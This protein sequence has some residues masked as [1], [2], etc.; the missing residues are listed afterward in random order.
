M[1]RTVTKSL[2]RGPRLKVDGKPTYLLV[3]TTTPWTLPG[4]VAVAVH[5]DIT[6]VEAEIRNKESGENEYVILAKERLDTLTDDYGIAREFLGKDLLGMQYE[7]LFDFVK[8]EKKAHYVIAGN[9]VSREEGTGLVHIA[10]AFGEEDMEAG[11]ANNLPVLMTMG[12]DGAF[13]KEVEPWAGIFV[14]SADPLIMNDLKKR[15]ILYKEEPYAHDYPFCW[16]CDS[17]LLYFAKKSW[18][19]RMTKVKTQLLK[20]NAKINWVPSHFKEGRFG[21]WLRDIR[22]WAFSR[23]RYWGTPLPLWQCE[24][25]GREEVIGSIDELV[26]QKFSTNTYYI[27]RHGEAESNAKR[28]ASSFPERRKN[29]LTKKGKREAEKQVASCARAGI[30]LIITSP[31]LRTKETAGIISDGLGGIKIIEDKGFREIDLGILN[32]AE[33]SDYQDFFSNEREKFSKGPPGG[34][35]LRNVKRRM[36]ETLNRIDKAHSH[37]TILI[38][39][40]EYPLWQL[41]GA[42]KGLDEEGLIGAKARLSLRTAEL[43]KLIYTRLPYASG[44]GLDLHR[45]YIDHVSFLCTN[46][47]RKMRR[48]PDLID[49]WFDSGA[50]PFAQSG[51]LGL[52]QIKN[53]KF[54]IKNHDI[55]FPADF[56]CEGVDQT[57]GWFYTLLA[58][59]TILG[60]D[61]PY[62]NVISHGLVLDKK[63]EKMSKSRG[64]TVD[65]WKVVESCGADAIRWYFFTVNQPA[66]VKKFDEEDVRD[67]KS[68]F[69]ETFY[70]IYRFFETYGSKKRK[71][72]TE[73]FKPQSKNFLDMWAISKL[74][75]LIDGVTKKLD[76]YDVVSAARAIELFVDDLSNW[77]VRRSRRR[78]Q[79]PRSRKEKNDAEYTLS[80]L[81]LEL[82]KLSA[83]FVPFVS[84]EIYRTIT[85]QK[86]RDTRRQ[87]ITSVHLE[88][89]PKAQNRLIH[90]NLNLQMDIVRTIVALGLNARAEKRIKVR[91]PLQT[92]EIGIPSTKPLSTRVEAL[93]SG[94]GKNKGFGDLSDLIREELNVKELRFVATHTQEFVRAKEGDIEVALDIHITPALQEE[95]SMRELVRNIQDMRREAGYEP[96][97]P[98]EVSLL[99]DETFSETVRRWSPFIKRET[100]ISLFFIG[101]RTKYKFDIE[102]ETAIEGH[103]LRIAIRKR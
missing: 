46:C 80:F 60:I 14:K 37:K 95:G 56:I 51:G 64:N 4:N 35:N 91:Q 102:K 89:W 79:H 94:V 62:K 43:R 83:P 90:K 76:E 25:C 33:I 58:I 96:H 53:L 10:P 30:D 78:F 3:W 41:A 18:F 7:P 39:S 49:V 19:I 93:K 31:L 103:S 65:P 59:S 38:I 84:E 101:G 82:A 28:L 66:D 15:H 48:V 34:E 45:P 55:L 92:L 85:R 27:M 81:L 70:H 2:V 97:W 6:Y 26:S 47:G 21:E 88:D 20:N 99:A 86:T 73:S 87:N 98:A 42:M 5:P 36:V 57:R 23:E 11:K 29:R 40:H 16:R 52:T 32:G 100:N 8:P 22:D 9:F 24:G 72:Y 12:E 75:E 17:P 61:P 69:V 67:R 71:P 50:M 68:R 74:N 13:I 1:P 44:G 54:K 77:Y 63:G